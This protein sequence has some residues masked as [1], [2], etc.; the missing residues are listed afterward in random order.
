MYDI[1]PC[2][3]SCM[4][5]STQTTDRYSYHYYNTG[6]QWYVWK[7]SFMKWRMGKYHTYIRANT[8]RQWLQHQMTN[9]KRTNKWQTWTEQK[10]SRRGLCCLACNTRDEFTVRESKDIGHCNILYIFV[11]LR[12]PCKR[13]Y[14]PPK[15]LSRFWK[16]GLKPGAELWNYTEISGLTLWKCGDIHHHWDYNAK[17]L[18]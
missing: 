7:I 11:I 13:Q 16:C 1:F 5:F 8:F 18:W 4:I 6:A 3:T 9:H 14:Y 17:I 12:V 2:V 15:R 10:L